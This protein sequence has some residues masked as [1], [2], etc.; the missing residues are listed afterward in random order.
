MSNPTT[1]M[2]RTP[3]ITIRSDLRPGDL[4]YIT[5]LHGIVYAREWGLDTTFEPYVARPLAEFVLAGPAAGRLW[6][7]EQGGD[8][9]GSLALVDAGDGTGQ[10]RW[11][12]LTQQVRGA[13][14]G[15][16]LMQDMLEEARVRGLRHLHLWTFDGLAAAIHLYEAFGFVETERVEHEMWGGP[17]VEVRMDLALT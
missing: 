16:R 2:G 6:I 9:V 13:G 3:H 5:Y 1:P 12:L 10:V 17:R 4:G 15:R 14:A 7:V 8:I 11:F